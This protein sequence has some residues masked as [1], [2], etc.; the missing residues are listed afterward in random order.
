M[1][2]KELRQ[3]LKDSK[4][5]KRGIMSQLKKKQ[6]LVYFLNDNLENSEMDV[7]SDDETISTKDA[8]RID[9]K[10]SKPRPL[11]MPKKSDVTSSRLSSIP[12]PKEVLFEKI[13]ELYPPIKEEDCLGVGEYDVRQTYHPIFKDQKNQSDMDIIFVGTASCSP[14]VTRG[15][16]CTALRLNGN[17]RRSLQGSPQGIDEPDSFS[18]GTWLFD[19]GE[20][21]QV[22]SIFRKPHFNR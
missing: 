6:D 19:C 12:S 17:T 8:P 10:L 5:N 22:S 3:L 1:T 16:S 11:S 21:T 13:Y 7:N 20:C 4:L 18:G 14:G 9:A 2:V 15:V